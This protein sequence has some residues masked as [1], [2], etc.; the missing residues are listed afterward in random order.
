VQ[1]VIAPLTTL[2][3]QAW[4]KE[5]PQWLYHYEVQRLQRRFVFKTY[6]LA[7]SF[8]AQLGLLAEEVAHHP[9]LYVTYRSVTVHLTTHD[10]NGVSYRDTQ[11]ALLCDKLFSDL[12]PLQQTE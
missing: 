12:S 10:A 5:H 11:F 8:V 7:L 2:Q 6:P 3:R 9:D 4:L 1:S